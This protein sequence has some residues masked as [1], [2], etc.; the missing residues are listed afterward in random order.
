M[1]TGS[2]IS[3]FHVGHKIGE[4]SFGEIYAVR[5][6]SDH[7]LYAL[8]VEPANTARKIIE[9]EAMVLKIVGDSPYFPKLISSGKTQTHSWYA[10]ELL[11]PSLST[12][13]NRLPTHR[14]SLST[15]LRVSL[16]ILKGLK[17]FHES[18]FIH[19]DLKPSNILLRKSREFPIAIIDFGLAKIYIDRKDGSI[20]PERAHPGFRGTAVYASPNA[21]MH[22]DLAR[23]DDLISWY[24]LTIDLLNGP[25]PWKQLDSRAEILH[26]KRT[27]HMDE[28]GEQIVKQFGEVWKTI[29][30]LNYEDRPNYEKIEDLLI[31][32]MSENN[33]KKDDEFDW[34]PQILKMDGND[35]N[36]IDQNRRITSSSFTS[37]A[38]EEM[39][40]FSKSSGLNSQP[41]LGGRRKEVNCCCMIC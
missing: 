1:L 35:E 24:Y 4:G 33:I 12:V 15:G 26:M 20:L 6:N 2:T 30:G 36:L 13:L 31:E 17:H 19:R 32:A 5:G 22:K 7:I 40:I 28:L 34:H 38:T 9:F 18:G 21:H 10:M 11:G 3:G 16:L 27:I 41:L 37:E 39:L 8:K 25:L 14:L 29:E 23:R